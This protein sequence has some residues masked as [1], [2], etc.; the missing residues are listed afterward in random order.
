MAK[1]AIAQARLKGRVDKNNVPPG[2]F[3][4]HSV[5]LACAQRR[6]ANGTQCAEILSN[7]VNG[8]LI[9]IHKVA[10]LRAAG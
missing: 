8:V 7:G 6:P 4:K 3:G 2:I 9:S 5:C 1:E 10:A